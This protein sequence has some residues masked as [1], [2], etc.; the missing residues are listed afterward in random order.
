MMNNELR[1]KDLLGSSFLASVM[2][3][4]EAIQSD[5]SYRFYAQQDDLLDPIRALPA[6]Q[7]LQ[8]L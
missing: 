2:G 7:A 5:P 8:D 4:I 3:H 6:F 1:S